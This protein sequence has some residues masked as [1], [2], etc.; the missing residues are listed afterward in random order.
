MELTQLQQ[1][2]EKADALR[3]DDPAAGLQLLLPAWQAYVL[4]GQTDNTLQ[5]K[6]PRLLF[7]LLLKSG[8]DGLDK[9]IALADT[10]LEYKQVQ[11]NELLRA[12]MLYLKSKALRYGGQHKPALAL[13]LDAFAIFEKYNF[14]KGNYI[15]VLGGLAYNYIL[16]GG[17][18]PAFK[19]N[20]QHFELAVRDDD[21]HQQ[22][23][24]MYY[25]GVLHSRIGNLHEAV[26]ANIRIIR[27][28]R[29]YDLAGSFI[30]SHTDLAI[31]LDKLGKPKMA[32]PFFEKGIK[33]YED[34]KD[35]YS[36]VWAV[37]QYVMSQHKN[38]KHE[39][40]VAIVERYRSVLLR[41]QYGNYRY[42]I[43]TYLMMVHIYQN[44]MEEAGS[45]LQVLLD[46][47]EHTMQSFERGNILDVLTFYYSTIGDYK[48]AYEYA[49]KHIANNMAEYDD[50]ERSRLRSLHIHQN[51]AAAK[52]EKEQIEQ[53]ALLKQQFLANIS[54]EIR[55][56][57]NAIIGLSSLLAEEDM[58][59][60]QKEIAGIIK[61]SSE[62]LLNVIN[63]V[64][65]NAKIESGR[66]TIENIPF[67]LT[68]L[69]N[70]VL[71]LL[72]H[73]A[74]E[75]GIELLFD[76]APDLPAYV[77]GDPTRLRQV[78]VNLLN[79]A[80]KFTT[81]GSVTLQVTAQPGATA[82][83]VALHIAVCDTGIGIPAAQLNN[84]FSGY[85]QASA[86]TARIY[87]GTG[88]GL[89]I[90]KELVQLMDGTLT[91][92]SHQ[93]QGSVFAFTL[94][95]AISQPPATDTAHEDFVYTGS[96]T[97]S[98]LVADDLEDN[99]Y[100]FSM[101]L[102]RIFPA[103]SVTLAADG[104]QAVANASAHHYD[105]IIMDIDMPVMNGIEAAMNILATSPQQKILGSSANVILGAGDIKEYGF[106]GFIPKPFTRWQFAETMRTMLAL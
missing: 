60:R 31:S 40:L 34:A 49:N 53:L 68:Y 51:L 14:E 64:L 73:K 35:E 99:R 9:T 98:F 32:T 3:K 79:N 37:L 25:L 76:A 55:S 22:A 83:N 106:A 33:D 46:A 27:F 15:E 82:G 16:L 85:K 90:S 95:M 87:G 30:S 42:L 86:D 92:Q 72:S 56:P 13:A 2:F 58:S 77:T 97:F 24:A 36:M 50:Q 54:H 102:K 63:D 81:Q 66:F 38:N 21:K 6:I 17:Y 70:D 1:I 26:I 57:M 48:Q 71:A 89:K 18:E 4:Q 44:E 7:S 62:N 93:G 47:L 59:P 104:K 74:K 28:V 91:V 103:S 8:A 100:V 11:D 29:K 20:H 52:R 19:Y 39:Q 41:N 80:V 105:L 94:P 5:V 84:I 67:S 69:L 12:E 61:R 96:K 75:K 88:L 65:D 43:A 101:L 10:Y 78:L 45:Y 23:I